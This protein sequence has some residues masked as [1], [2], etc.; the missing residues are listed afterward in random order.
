MEQVYRRARRTAG[1]VKRRV[2]RQGSGPISPVAYSAPAVTPAL[3]GTRNGPFRVAI[4]GAGNQ[5]GDIAKGVLSLGGAA[6]VA[7]LADRSAPALESLKTRVSL[8]DTSFYDDAEKL[9]KAEQALDLVC[10]ATNTPSHLPL[11]RMAIDAGFKRLMIEKPMS[12]SVKAAKEF[13]AYAAE[14]GAVFAV[15]HGRRWSLD[16]AAIKRYIASSSMGSIRQMT[17][18]FGSGGL[19]MVGV[20]F[21]DLVRYL[22]GSEIAWAV[23]HLDEATEPNRRGAEFHDPEGFG[24]LVFQN[25]ARALLDFSQDL[26]YKGKFVSIETDYGRIEVDERRRQWT[27]VTQQGAFS[28]PFADRTA[29]AHYAARVIASLLSGETPRANGQDGAAV[30]EAIM[31]LHLSHERNHAPVTL[32]LDEAG[33]SKEIAFP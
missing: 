6:V 4:I 26:L 16:Y 1:M 19:G 20:H 11:A 25:G 12:T 15:N 17:V 2:L 27:A 23:G 9:F 7:A 32:P 14:K 13:S 5:G 3:N 30:I 22:I 31:A 33:Q 8:P 29:S 18:T 21:I 10:I 24:L 28:F